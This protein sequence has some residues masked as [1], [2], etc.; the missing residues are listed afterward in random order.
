MQTYAE[1]GEILEEV[2]SKLPKL[3]KGILDTVYSSDAGTN[4]GRAVG[5]LYKELVE[6]GVP[7]E[8]AMEIAKDYMLSFKDLSLLVNKR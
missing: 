7:R 8:E 6:A 3:L 5:N 4:I 1:V 2:S